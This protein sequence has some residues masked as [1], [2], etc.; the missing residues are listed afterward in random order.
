MRESC[1]DNLILFGESSLR[2]AVSQ[3]VEHYHEERN[4]QGFENKLIRPEFA[5]F[6]AEGSVHRRNRL[7]GLLIY[8]Y[9]TAA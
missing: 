8:Y 3:F 5:K 2:K 6:P 9:R 7:G 1:L 4:H